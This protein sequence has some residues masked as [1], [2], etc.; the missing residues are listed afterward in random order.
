MV[1]G[2]VDLFQLEPSART[3]AATGYF[4]SLDYSGAHLLS[5][6]SR[7]SKMLLEKREHLLPAVNRRLWTI[8]YTGIV[9]EAVPCARVH[10]K[11]VVLPILLQ[12][13]LQLADTLGCRV[14]VLFSK[15]AE[16]WTGQVLRIVD[17]CDWLCGCQFLL[18]LYHVSAPTIDGCVE[19]FCSARDEEGLTSTRTGPEDSD[20]PIVE[21]QRLEIAGRGVD[22]S[23]YA[24]IRYSS[25]PSNLCRHIIRAAVAKSEVDVWTYRQVTVVGEL[26]RK[27]AI[28]LVPARHVMN[29]HHPGKGSGTQW[30]RI[31]GV[32]YLSIM[33]R[34]HNGLGK[35]SLIH[36][37]RIRMHRVL[38]LRARLKN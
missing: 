12:L 1:I 22:V 19:G 38:G 18:C 33:A 5:P 10:V 9:E 15:Q 7:S 37:S 16:E 20:L 13:L 32:D 28:Q 17:G 25:G 26:S 36:V 11:L 30:S 35:H 21:R 2:D 27:L 29:Q 14:L 8:A 23:D 34:Q 6:P 4:R 31:V 24:R 3:L